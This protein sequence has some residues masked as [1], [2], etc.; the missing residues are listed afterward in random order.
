MP[1]ARRSTPC[2]CSE[3]TAIS[4]GAAQDARQQRRPAPARPCASGRTARRADV[5]DFRGGPSCPATSCTA[6]CRL[7]PSA[8]FI[9]WKPRQIAKI[10]MPRLSAARI[11]GSVVASRAGS[12][13]RAGSRR[14]CAVVAGVDVGGG[15]GQHDA[16]AR[17]QHGLE[18]ERFAQRRHDQ[19]RAAGPVDDRVDVFV[20][21]RMVGMVPDLARAGWNDNDWAA[22]AVSPFP[23]YAAFR[24]S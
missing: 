23:F 18:V 8:T 1:A 19:R 21:H 16:V 24:P 12:C 13:G 7:P 11:S 9:S 10:G 15:T 5:R 20:L 22:H 14:S 3:L 17:G 2:P 6:W 4:V